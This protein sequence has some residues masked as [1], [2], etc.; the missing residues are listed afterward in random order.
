MTNQ[1]LFILAIVAIIVIGSGPWTAPR[2]FPVETY[3]RTAHVSV[4][5]VILLLVVLRLLHLI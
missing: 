1:T 5:G 3:P 4:A 2:Y